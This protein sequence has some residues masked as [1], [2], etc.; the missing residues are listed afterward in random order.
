MT[1]PYFIA[2]S[3]EATLLAVSQSAE[4]KRQVESVLIAA[5]FLI[6]LFRISRGVR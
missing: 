1:L 2:P 5:L 4:R 6:L 3:I